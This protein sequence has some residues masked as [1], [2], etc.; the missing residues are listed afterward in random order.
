MAQS[1]VLEFE[2]SARAEDSTRNGEE[3]RGKNERR[4]RVYESGIN[5]SR[6][7]I[8]RFARATLTFGT[9]PKAQLGRESPRWRS[10]GA[11]FREA[12]EIF[13]AEFTENA[14][15]AP[16]RA[17]RACRY[18]GQTFGDAM[19]RSSVSRMKRV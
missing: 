16:F 3:C 6:S 10:A 14:P 7:D 8:S 5:G 9:R 18:G 13:A 4:R 2:G 11:G 1:Q 19:A 17:S 12:S 15:L